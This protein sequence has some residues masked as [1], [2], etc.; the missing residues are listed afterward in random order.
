LFGF[1]LAELLVTLMIF[2]CLS[3]MVIPSYFEYQNRH[4]LSMKAWEIKRALE[5]A[6]SIAV[7]QNKE[8]KVCP[9]TLDHRCA[10]E[11]G[12]RLLVFNDSNSDHQWH[13]DERI[14]KDIGIDEFNITLSASRRKYIRFKPSGES[15]ESGNILVC[16]ADKSDFARQII[17][18]YS[19]RIRLSKDTDLD[20]YDNKSGRSIICKNH[21]VI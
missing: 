14:Y 9:A 19:G 20:G 1:T 8:I 2:S 7:S 17:V 12:V 3:L 11:S 18:F 13:Q 16:N 4:S 21:K 15:R 10:I 5:L 6:R